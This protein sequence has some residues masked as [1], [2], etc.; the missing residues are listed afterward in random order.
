MSRRRVLA[1]ATA[2][3][4]AL[5]CGG[6][7]VGLGAHARTVRLRVTLDFGADTLASLSL[8]K[9]PAGETALSLL[10]RLY[11]SVSTT[12]EPL[13][14]TSSGIISVGG[15][16]AAAPERWT[17]FVDGVHAT[18]SAASLRIHPGDQVWFDLHDQSAATTIPAIVGSFPEPFTSGIGGR[19]YPT[20]L[21]CG[22]QFKGPCATLTRALLRDGVVA[23][24]GNPGYGSGPDT[25]SINVGTWHELYGEVAAQLIRYGPGASGVYALVL[26]G[27]ARLGLEDAAGRVVRT[28]GAGAGLVAATANA[29]DP[30]PTWI[31]TGTDAAGVRAALRALNPRALSGHF[32]VATQ[33]GRLYP[34]P[35]PAG[36]R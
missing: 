4:L 13:G 31:V 3:A 34:L 17:L 18:S 23:S 9:V 8:A 29:Q 28:L 25:L 20:T 30:A 7:G 5:G 12:P 27:G 1:A 33:G 19:R 24:P 21:E 11:P 32:A 36:S 15:H 35:L 2:L 26:G 6:C 22:A 10:R 16:R 14:S